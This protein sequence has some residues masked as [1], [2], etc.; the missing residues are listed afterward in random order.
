LIAQCSLIQLKNNRAVQVC[1]VAESDTNIDFA[2]FQCINSRRIYI[3]GVDGFYTLNAGDAGFGA[4]DFYIKDQIFDIAEFIT[5]S[6]NTAFK[7][8]GMLVIPIGNF[9]HE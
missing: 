2:I 8:I 1:A 6:E 4:V 7:T 3:V 5:V 9:F